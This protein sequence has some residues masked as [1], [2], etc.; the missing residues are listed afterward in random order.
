LSKSNENSVIS[1]PD[2]TPNWGDSSQVDT[3]TFYNKTFY[4]GSNYN[5]WCNGENDIKLK[6]SCITA[7]DV[8]ASAVPQYK[9][10]L[11]NPK[12]NDQ[13]Q[14]IYRHNFYDINS[15]LWNR[16]IRRV[17]N[18]FTGSGTNRKKNYT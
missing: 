11:N 3:T 14:K 12:C 6:N 13:L 18:T 10:C 7:T 9:E 16:L 15:T 1:T 4:D 5:S 8:G 2:D 17:H